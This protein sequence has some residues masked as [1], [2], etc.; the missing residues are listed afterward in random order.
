MAR[1]IKI[2][3]VK[4]SQSVDDISERIVTLSSLDVM[5]IPTNILFFETSSKGGDA[6]FFLDFVIGADLC[7]PC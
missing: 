1:G 7:F 4:I 5:Q 3:Q 2:S 6:N